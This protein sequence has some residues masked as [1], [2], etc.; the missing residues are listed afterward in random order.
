[1]G[2][3]IMAFPHPVA[4]PGQKHALA[5]DGGADRHLAPRSRSARLLEGDVEAVQA[6]L[7][8]HGGVAFRFLSCG[9]RIKLRLALAT[10]CR[11]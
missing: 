4:G 7:L 3:G 5:Q 9:L 10:G 6:L 2:G 11:S 1:M 8:A